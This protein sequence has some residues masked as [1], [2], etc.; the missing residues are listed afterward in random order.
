MTATSVQEEESTR[1]ALFMKLYQEAFPLVARHVSKMGGS[2]E[3]AKDIFQDAL[4]V[5]YEKVLVSG[6]KLKYKEKAYLFGI[7]KFLWIKCYKE[8]DKQ[9]TLN[10]SDFV[11][12]EK[13]DLA[14][15]EYEEISS[16]KLMN[17]LAHAGQK[18]MQLL[19]A[20]YYEKLDMETL[21]GR[22]GFSG[23]R[24]ATAQK[25]KCLEKV[26]ETVKAKSLTYEDIIA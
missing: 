22:F 1:K 5:Y 2:F 26:K 20:F 8:N 9:V 18:C 13:I 17:L 12:N 23:A 14:D 11:F 4:V 16:P 10:S 19:S 6:L 3:E 7:A 25:F 24:S 21:A 15:A